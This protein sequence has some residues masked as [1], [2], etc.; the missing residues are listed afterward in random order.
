M[1]AGNN[2]RKKDATLVQASEHVLLRFDI[3]AIGLRHGASPH[4]A[5]CTADDVLARPN[6]AGPLR[7]ITAFDGPYPDDLIDGLD[8]ALYPYTVAAACH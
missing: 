1:H 5:T 7:T 6:V 4:R 8:A 3:T 2:A